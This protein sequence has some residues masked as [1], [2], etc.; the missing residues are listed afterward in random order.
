[1]TTLEEIQHAHEVLGLFPYAKDS[2][3]RTS[4]RRLA[5]KTHPD[6]G[7]SA[8]AFREVQEAFELLSDPYTKIEYGRRLD[9]E[10]SRRTSTSQ[11]SDR[12]QDEQSPPPPQRETPHSHAS[13]TNPKPPGPDAAWA[14]KAH[15]E[16]LR[17]IRE[18]HAANEAMAASAV[19]ARNN[20][21]YLW[22]GLLVFFFGNPF[23][24]LLGWLAGWPRQPAAPIAVFVVAVALIMT[25]FR[26]RSRS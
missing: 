18:R 14:A 15:E 25:W 4:Y 22:A 13:R 16:R 19:I 5:R 11:Q 9:E 23:L 10:P 6:A 12:S 21:K 17:I 7:G 8:K 26:R 24:S 3:L 2:D 1:M 20:R